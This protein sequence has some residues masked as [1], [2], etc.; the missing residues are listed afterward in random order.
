MPRKGKI[1][2]TDPALEDLRDIRDHVSRDRPAAA[3]QLADRLKKS[4]LR[5]GDHPLSGR[6]VPEFPGTNLREVI[7]APY[8]IVYEP[9]ERDVVI[10][11]VWHGRMDLRRS[12]R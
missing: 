12:Q 1:L 8:R 6:S 4:V 5:L 10:L 7:V 9:C 2:W 3:R 11:R